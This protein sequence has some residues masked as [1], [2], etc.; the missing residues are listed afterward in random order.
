M[1]VGICHEEFISLLVLEQFT[2]DIILGRPWLSQR[3]PEILWQTREILKLFSKSSLFS[4]SSSSPPSSH[5]C[6]GCPVYID[7]KSYGETISQHTT[8]LRSSFS[9]VFCPKKTNQLPPHRPWDCAIDHILGEQVPHGKIYSL[10]IPEQKAMDEYIVVALQQG[11]IRPSKS[12]AA[13]SFFFVAKKDGGLMI[14]MNY[15]AF[16]QMTVKFRYQLPLVPAA[17]EQLQG[18]I[19]FT[20]LDLSSAYNLI[21]IC[22]GMSGS[23]HLWPLLATMN[24]GLYCIGLSMPPPY[25]RTS[26]MKCSRISLTSLC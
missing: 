19:G 14:C 16:N 4:T 24:T 6:V 9:D 21:W 11:Y 2:M 20:K 18:A 5:P 15:R 7:W 22:R 23:P 3:Q 10:S 12:P 13:S 25:S 17:L 26:C 8:M 1:Q